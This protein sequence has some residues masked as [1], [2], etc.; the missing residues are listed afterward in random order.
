[1][2]KSL[3]LLV[4]IAMVFSMFA[5]VAAA[6]EL[7]TQGKFEA[8]KEA[9]ILEG[10]TGGDPAFDSEMTRAEFATVV[11]RVLNKVGNLEGTPATFDDVPSSHW[12]SNEIGAIQKQG[13]IQG[14]GNNKFAPSKSVT[15]QE[16][17]KVVVTL[18]GLEVDP[19]A[20]VS[21]K[22][23]AWAQPY[24]AAAEKAGLIPAQDDYT[25][26]ALRG[27]LVDVTYQAYQE[28]SKAGALKIAKVEQTNV[29]EITVS[30][31]RAAEASEK[32]DLTFE[33]K[34]GLVTYNI[35]A[36]WADDNKSVALQSNY[37][38]AGE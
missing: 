11:F 8:L 31:N 6:E 25:V 7:D 16:L 23:A 17:I 2:K 9:G 19:S 37:L 28:I 30:F 13:I 34:S 18:L 5:T 22:A 4:A 14:V 36:K 24:V 3:S 27:F 38:P 15:K 12:A 35:T 21:G 26:N 33:V 10:R 1:M 32:S 29:G 20:T